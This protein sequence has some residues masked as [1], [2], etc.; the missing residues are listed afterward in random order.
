VSELGGVAEGD[1]GGLVVAC[2]AGAVGGK[3]E[4]GAAGQHLAEI[5]VY[6]AAGEGR[7]LGEVAQQAAALAGR[8][9]WRRG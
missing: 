5:L 1:G 9:S 4:V 2:F 8:P 6:E 7:D 3:G